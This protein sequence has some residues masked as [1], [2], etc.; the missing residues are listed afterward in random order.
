MS[1]YYNPLDISCKSVLGAVKQS[2]K[3]DITVKSDLVGKCYLRIKTDGETDFKSC[4]M[5]SV[6]G[7]F[8]VSLIGLETGLYWYYFE[9]DGIYFGKGADLC[10]EKFAVECYQLSV[11]DESYQT[12]DWIKGGII[13]QIFPDRF[14]SSGNFE[15]ANGKAKAPCW[16]ALPVYKN[17]E[18][19]VLNNE[20]FGGNFEGIR[21]KLPYLKQLNVSAIYLN[22]VNKSFSSHRYDTGDYMA[23]DPLIGT[24]SDFLRLKADAEDFGIKIIFDGVYNHTGSDSV[25]FNKEGNYNSVGAYQSTSS[26]YF[27]WYNFTKHPTEYD[28]WW[29]FKTLPSIKKNSQSFQNFITQQVFKRNFELGF[30]GVRLDVVDELSQTFIENIRSSAKRL[31]PNALIIGEV[32]E[33][34]TNKIAYGERRK[35][36]LGK[37]LD[38]VMNYP[39]RS[40]IIDFLLSGDTHNLCLIIREQIN[41]YPPCALHALMN[42]LST[43]DSPRIITVLG[44][45]NVVTDKD[46]MQFET[47]SQ[48]EYEK[49]KTLAKLA[50]TLLFTLYGVPS[51]YYGDEVGL[52]G[53]LDPYNRKTYPWGN[54]DD[55]MLNFVKTLGEIRAQNGV[56]ACGLTNVLYAQKG[57]FVFERTDQNAQIVVAIN[58]RVQDVE[59]SFNSPMRCLFAKKSVGNKVT[60]K[61]NQA[62]V[63][64]ME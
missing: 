61:Q 33:D 29:G 5:Q 11:Y 21:Q 49:G 64:E 50:Y 4:L 9:I 27:E 52:W 42:V 62:L 16:N 2:Q 51:V 23:F 34:A 47:L 40:A 48:A 1:F 41:N 18:G 46:E 10:A 43:H 19:K 60:L 7:G 39:L 12:P 36:F 24:D 13:Y 8:F 17:A 45:N 59:L 37:Q 38:S 25:Y 58:R 31:N 14:Y 15:V 26:T 3:L 56:F 32:W 54:E 44:R 35:Y 57:V 22:P 55:D 20:F 28:S 53:N 30:C 6:S 63:L